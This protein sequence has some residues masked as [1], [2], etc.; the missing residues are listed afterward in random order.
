M[1]KKGRGGDGA[2][3]L[4]CWGGVSAGG[5]ASV[6]M[7]PNKRAAIK[8]KNSKKHMTVTLLQKVL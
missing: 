8:V 5:N 1:G 6:K 2:S 4:R 7:G 3:F